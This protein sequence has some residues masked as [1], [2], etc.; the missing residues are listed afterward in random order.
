MAT[1]V[2]PRRYDQTLAPAG[3][4]ASFGVR[5]TESLL[6]ELYALVGAGS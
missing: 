2:V 5:R 1:H 4:A 6:G 3:I